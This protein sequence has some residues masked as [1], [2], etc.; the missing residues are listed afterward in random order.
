MKRSGRALDRFSWYARR[1]RSMQ[2][3]EVLWRAGQAMRRPPA[4]VVINRTD[5]EWA[6]SLEAFR[7]CV[8]RPVLFNR[9][10][11]A[12]IANRKP[13]SVQELVVV[14]DGFCNNTFQF[15]GYEPVTLSQPINWHHDP[16]SGVW[17][18]DEPSNRIDHRAADGDV[19]WI[20]ELNRLQHL[21]LLAQAWIFSGDQRYSQVA[22]EHLD[23]WIEQNPPGRGIAWRGAFE[24]GLRSISI[25]LAVQ[26]LRDSPHLTVERYRRVVHVLA[27]SA[28]RCWRE[29]SLFSSANNHLIGEMAGLAVVALL[30]PDLDA[31]VEW[32]QQAVQTLAAEAGNLIL[33]DGCGSEQSVAYQIATVELLQLVAALL[34]QR[35]GPVPVA[36]TDAIARSSAFLAALV[37]GHDPDPRYGDADQEFAVR[38]GPERQRTV[39]EHLEVTAA[40]GWGG[41]GGEFCASS[42]TAEWYRSV[43]D[44][45][46]G[47]QSV[48][49][50]ESAVA[51]QD[52]VAEQG[53]LVVLRRGRRRIT[54]DVGPLG[55][56]SIAAHGHADALS[57]TIS[58][59][60]DDLIGDPGTG[61][62][63]RHPRWRAAMRGTRAHST[64]C[65]DGENQSVIGGPFL[66]SRHAHTR[67]RGFD[68][69]AGVID[70]EHD[71]YHR[72]PGR[73]GHRRWLIAPPE[74][75]S[76]LIVDLIT[77]TGDHQ[78]R[79]IW[80]TH[81]SLDAQICGDRH[82]LTRGDVPVLE[83]IHAGTVPL[84]LDGS[85]GD[86]TFDLGWWSDLL[87]SRRPA[88]WL[89]A[90]CRGEI[91]VAI[92]TLV[93][94]ADGVVTEGLAVSRRGDRL[95]V[96]WTEGVV[97]R[98]VTV[99]ADADATVDLS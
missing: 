19:K 18:P 22:F 48:V 2:L 26:A 89:S 41:I 88:W 43:A 87:E 53:G 69:G 68:L 63:Y 8:D 45:V 32:K 14:A 42:L 16:I 34:V 90:V 49:C 12:A 66:W 15:F 98:A 37:G 51:P 76:L 84:D 33:P 35:G 46:S 81:P 72:L 20:W 24:A 91:P 6:E 64:V 74:W 7:R 75:R 52:F 60:G 86:E 9:E 73:V 5:A 44:C 13:E 83:L 36:I 58:Q 47:P 93:S 10:R 62:Y 71:G 57:V 17:W 38:L 94:P 95:E 4:E 3:R 99:R 85:F 28:D 79:S 23:S 97:A 77:G 61:S 67:L 50:G 11:A 59:D 21:P 96:V 56:L 27:L 70:A 30:F 80:P 40:L 39:R 1:L 25:A 29:R 65:V 92:A 78:I 55:Y 54:M 82:I 31:A